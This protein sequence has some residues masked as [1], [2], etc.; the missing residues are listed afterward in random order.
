[1]QETVLYSAPQTADTA[2]LYVLDKSERVTEYSLSDYA[3]I[4]RQTPD[5]RLEVPLNSSIASRSHGEIQQMEGVYY[6][7]DTDSLNGTYINGIPYGKN[8]PNKVRRL[9]NGDVL[10]ID[11]KNLNRSHQDAVLIIFLLGNASKVWKT[12]DLDAETGD[13][14]MRLFQDVMLPLF[15]V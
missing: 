11:Q 8:S 5:S 13:I 3:K 14:R 6:Y 12:V 15:T 1:M 10:R 4:G 7:R 9:E 2:T